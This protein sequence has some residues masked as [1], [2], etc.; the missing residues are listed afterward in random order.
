MPPP[1]AHRNLTSQQKETFKR[2]I[3]EGA[4]VRAALGVLSH[5]SDRAARGEDFRIG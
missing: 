1:K 5:L 3:A 2:W 4:A